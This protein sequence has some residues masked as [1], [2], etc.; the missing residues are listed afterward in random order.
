MKTT[1]KLRR[2]KRSSPSSG[3]AISCA[4]TNPDQWLT[5]YED[6]RVRVH[7]RNLDTGGKAAFRTLD[8]RPKLKSDRD[9]IRRLIWHLNLV[10]AGHEGKECQVC[11][12][13]SR[14]N[15]LCRPKVG[16]SAIVRLRRR[17][18]RD[19]VTYWRELCMKENVERLRLKDA[20]EVTLRQNAHLADGDVCTL[21]LLKDSIREPNREYPEQLST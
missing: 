21:K 9:A 10:A 19:Q 18:L 12:C 13:F 7:T 11:D 3:S 4:A 14:T 1:P 16:S 20:I 15:Q 6:G 17:P 5:L 8:Y 2:P